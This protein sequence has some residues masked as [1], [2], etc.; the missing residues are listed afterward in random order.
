MVDH[1]LLAVVKA[2][3]HIGRRIHLAGRAADPKAQAGKLLR[4]QLLD[5][6]CHPPLAGR[7]PPGRRRMVPNGRSRSSW[8]T[9]KLL[10]RDFIEAHQ[11]ADRLAGQVHIGLG[12]ATTNFAAFQRA[13]SYQ[14][15]RL[16]PRQRDAHCFAQ[17]DL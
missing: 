15:F 12:L 5:D 17:S 6:R 7:P 10:E 14:R 13:H 4:A 2:L 3:Q 9:I 1:F 8:A 11:P 16:H